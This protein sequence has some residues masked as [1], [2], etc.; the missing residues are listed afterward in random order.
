[1]QLVSLQA[2]DTALACQLA[3]TNIKIDHPI[4]QKLIQT[5]TEG[6]KK[7]VNKHM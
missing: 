1:M 6:L 3:F 4:G 2:E 7:I 5:Q